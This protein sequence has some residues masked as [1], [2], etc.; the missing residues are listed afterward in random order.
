MDA[1]KSITQ[2]ALEQSP[3]NWPKRCDIKIH[4][5][6]EAWI[7]NNSNI[8]LL[9]APETHSHP[10]YYQP[11][12]GGIEVGETPLEACVR[13]VWEETGMQMDPSYIQLVRDNFRIVIGDG[14][15]INKSIYLITT[16]QHHIT[17]SN[18]HIN[19]V[20]VNKQMVDSHLFW[21]SNKYTYSLV[22]Q[23]FNA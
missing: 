3:G 13:E 7:Y 9:L 21:L 12:T 20:W 23:M 10:E 22:S 19:Y 5:S 17:I 14:K 11:V 1:T 6:I 16:N 4:N 8:L 2:E 18:E 15:A